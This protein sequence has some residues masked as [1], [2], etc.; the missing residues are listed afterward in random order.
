MIK[1]GRAER[2]K[3]SFSSIVGGGHHRVGPRSWR[4]VLQWTSVAWSAQHT[5]LFFY[6]PSLLPTWG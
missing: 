3:V 6:F 2:R 4:G 1:T 5:S